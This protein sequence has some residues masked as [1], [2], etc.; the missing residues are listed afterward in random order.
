MELQ[1]LACTFIAQDLKKISDIDIEMINRQNIVKDAS[2]SPDEKSAAQF[3]WY[4]LDVD[5]NE[6]IKKLYDDYSIKVNR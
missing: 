3:Q 4:C 5:L 2:S 1:L 6:A